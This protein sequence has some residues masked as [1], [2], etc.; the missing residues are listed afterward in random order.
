M[1]GRKELKGINKEGEVERRENKEEET[2]RVMYRK[3]EEMM[4]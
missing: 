2:E 4:K 1:V 3:N